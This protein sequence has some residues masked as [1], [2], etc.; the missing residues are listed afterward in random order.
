MNQT[1]SSTLANEGYS[2]SLKASIVDYTDS[3]AFNRVL[4]GI[5][6][7][8]TS[9]RLSIAFMTEIDGTPP[10]YPSPSID[11]ARVLRHLS[12][13]ITN[14]ASHN[15]IILE[16]GDFSAIAIWETTTYT[17]EPF[18]AQ[19]Q[20]VGPLRGDW[21]RKVNDLKTLHLGTKID[22][23]GNKVLNPH[24]H[25]GFLV[26]NPEVPYVPDAISAV[27]KPMLQQA[28]REGVPVWLEATYEHAVEVYE[29]YG[30]RIVEVV[31]IGKGSRNELGWP[32]NGGRGTKAW[33]MILDGHLSG[34]ADG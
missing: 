18:T 33:T 10:P 32:E 5:A 3:A 31:T 17:G 29:H 22:K 25:L 26:R 6:S 1:T 23:E 7:A 27:I 19:L 34:S 20:D 21:R 11:Q 13:G 8:F 2:A 16:A 9:A 24:Y 28:I 12:P 4:S 14:T 30:F 15:A